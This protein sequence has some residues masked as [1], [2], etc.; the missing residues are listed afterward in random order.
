M[1]M[2]KKSQSLRV[3]PLPTHE[4]H[5]KRFVGRVRQEPF[6]VSDDLLAEIRTAVILGR[7]DRGL[8]WLTSRGNLLKLLNPGNRNVAGFVSY[9]AHCAELS[10]GALGTVRELVGRFQPSIRAK[11][12]LNEYAHRRLADGIVALASGEMDSAAAHFDF[13]VSMGAQNIAGQDLLMLAHFW[14][15]TSLRRTGQY[16]S[17]LEHAALG[18]AIAVELGYAPAA[19]V[20]KAL[21]A[22]LNIHKEKPGRALELLREAETDLRHPEDWLWSANIHAAYGRVALEEG[23]Y[24]LALDHLAKAE[25]LYAAHC[26]LH[27]NMARALVGKACACRLIAARIAKTIDTHAAQ[28]RKAAGRDPSATDSAARKRVEQTRGEA[29]ANLAKA[30]QIYRGLGRP[31]LAISRGLGTVKIERGLLLADCGEL[32]G[33]IREAGDAYE[34]GSNEKDYVVMARAR[35]LQSRVE[36]AQCEEGIDEDPTRHA[37]R[38]HDYAKD[39]LTFA[40]RTGQPRL[41]ASAYISLGLILK[42]D[43]FGNA[44]AASECCQRAGEFLNPR[45]RDMLWEEYQTLS[46]KVLRSG[47][48]D[49]KLRKWSQ[50]VVDNKTFQQMT[51]EFA[52]LVIPSVWLR[53]GKNISRVVTKLSISPKKVR[54]I[55]LRAGLKPAHN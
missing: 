41:L 24:E 21:E 37:H 12:A 5:A 26:P 43:F 52:D 39:A 32:D 40:E 42:C 34:L 20:L 33:A 46:A 55:L 7:V 29:L 30:A 13:A 6:E 22:W 25:G 18:R 14:K 35:L 10:D 16:D 15:A 53:E 4:S 47:T 54:R 1:R 9:L 51:E 44:D 48:V 8:E 28:R 11:L 38:A 19:G 23:R 36:S 17:A 49:A 31:A 45:N 27:R 50:G 3:M 2:Q